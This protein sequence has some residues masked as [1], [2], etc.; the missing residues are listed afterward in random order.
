MLLKGGETGRV[1]LMAY[2]VSS[3]VYPAVVSIPILNMP[4]LNDLPII[5]A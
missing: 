3:N 5:G 2:A 1:W 4:L